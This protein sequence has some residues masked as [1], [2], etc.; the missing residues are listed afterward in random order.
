[1][2]Q[3]SVLERC[4]WLESNG[5][6]LPNEIEAT[7]EEVVEY[8]AF[9]RGFYTEEDFRRPIILGKRIVVKEDG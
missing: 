7:R 8:L 9:L 4:L 5:G 3:P 1:M 2:K 6:E